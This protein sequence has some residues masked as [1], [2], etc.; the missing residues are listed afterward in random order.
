MYEFGSHAPMHD[1]FGL[2]RRLLEKQAD[3]IC[4]LLTKRL[5]RKCQ[6]ESVGLMSEAGLRSLW[7]EICVARRQDSCW[8]ELY[9]E[10]L[11]DRMILLVDALP[12][13]ERQILWLMTN[14]GN[15]YATSPLW[16]DLGLLLERG[17]PLDT[18][19]NAPWPSTNPTEWPIDSRK[20]ASEVIHDYV[21]SECMNYE[22]SRIRACTGY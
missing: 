10:H 8:N 19:P 15:E 17:L 9:D 13:I 18:K 6:A 1:P 12:A 3:A 21:M 14:H 7:E 4:E 5:I 16:P 2:Y 11:K 20:I 22:N